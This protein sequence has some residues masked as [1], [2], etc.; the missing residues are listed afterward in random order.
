MLNPKLRSKC[1]EFINKH[2]CRGRNNRQCN[3][4]TDKGNTIGHTYS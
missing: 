4:A 3:N 1:F 2:T